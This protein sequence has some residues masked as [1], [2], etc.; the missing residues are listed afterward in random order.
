MT[1]PVLQLGNLK[2]S[3]PAGLVR[4]G[5]ILLV[6]GVLLMV[7]AYA[8]D[9]R[10]AAF[11][12]VLVFLFCAS[13]ASGCI[14]LIAL[15]YISGAV[16]SV[17][18]RRVSEFLAG[19]TPLLP[20]LAL[21]LLFH[22][23]E[24]FHWAQADVV[25]ADQILKEKSPFLNVPFF[26]ARFAVICG[27]WGL[28]F[29]IFTR[30]SL[31]QDESRDQRLTT[32]N[33][34]LAALFLPV[35]AITLTL[36]AIDWGMSLEPHWFSTIFGVYFFS[37]TALA[38]L[39]AVTLVVVILLQAGYLPKLRRD[40]LYSLGALMFAFVNFWAYIAFSQFMLI[41]YAN[42]PD[43]TF[44]FIKRWHNG[45]EVI[46]VLLIVVHFAVPYFVLLPQEAKMNL[47]TLKVM[48]IWILAAHFLDVYWLV[49]PSYADTVS[50]GWSELGVPLVIVGLGIVLLSWKLGRHNVVPVGDPKLERGLEFRL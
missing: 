12:N 42:L 26:I 40:H 41:W 14:F 20:I 22:M 9:A 46:S 37:G 10:R 25:A 11:D 39:A 23:G 32:W 15:E 29:W 7:G 8:T 47:R 38:A 16:W 6:V 44:W 19:L 36:T 5:W 2:K 31:R 30:N 50:L 13:I 18:V 45:W 34:R 1:T 49:M 35:F 43:E 21:P 27:V 17:P 33:I 3:M 24:L 4:I 28:F 48:S